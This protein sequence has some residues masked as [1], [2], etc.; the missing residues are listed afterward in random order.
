MQFSFPSPVFS[1]SPDKL[2]REYHACS[3]SLSVCPSPISTKVRSDDQPMYTT[4]TTSSEMTR[5]KRTLFHSKQYE[6]AGEVMTSRY[7]NSEECGTSMIGLITFLLDTEHTTEDISRHSSLGCW[8][9]SYAQPTP[10]YNNHPSCCQA[11]QPPQYSNTLSSCLAQQTYQ[12]SNTLSSC[13]A[14]QTYQFSNT[15]SSCQAQQTYQFSNTLSSCQAQELSLRLKYPNLFQ[16]FAHCSQSTMGENVDFLRI[17]LNPASA[18][19]C[20]TEIKQRAVR[21]TRSKRPIKN[22]VKFVLSSF[23]GL[24]LR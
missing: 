16:S 17:T 11:Q 5:A 18:N 6:E 4:R 14:Q 23:K 10:Q 22:M 8:S 13:L 2:I 24:K 15:L 3:D 21:G 9:E 20:N 1:S 12:F 19:R 7:M